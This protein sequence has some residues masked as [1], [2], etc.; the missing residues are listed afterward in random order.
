[1]S[2]CMRDFPGRG[3]PV[4]RWL[5]CLLLVVLLL[6]LTDTAR[7]WQGEVIKVLD[8]DSLVVRRGKKK[9]EIRL[10]GI[11]APEYRQRYALVART[12]LSRLLRGHQVEVE[13]MDV[14]DYGREVALVRQQ[15]VLVNEELVRLGA[16]WVYPR[17]CRAEPYCSRW[18]ELEQEARRERRGLWL[19]KSPQPP[20]DWRHTPEGRGRK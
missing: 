13:R 16:A 20:W 18:R 14:D 7:A 4:L 2:V 17:Y 10:Y 6:V 1:V 15:G 11:D 5:S 3:T 12:N 19:D 9:V 8:G